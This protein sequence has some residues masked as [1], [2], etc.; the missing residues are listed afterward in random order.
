MV[1][2]NVGSREDVDSVVVDHRQ[3]H[4]ALLCLSERGGGVLSSQ[5]TLQVGEGHNEPTG[6]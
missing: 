5:L 4:S 1:A 2:E 6:A 3:G